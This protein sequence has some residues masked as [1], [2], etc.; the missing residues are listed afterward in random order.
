MNL[1]P[2][3]S[4]AWHA[5]YRRAAAQLPPDF[6]DCVLRALHAPANAVRRARGQFLLAA[7]TAAVCLLVV[8]LVHVYDLEETNQEAL[9]DWQQISAQADSFASAP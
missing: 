8:V 5:L 6:A 9:A 3:T 2:D 4:K 1:T 7:C